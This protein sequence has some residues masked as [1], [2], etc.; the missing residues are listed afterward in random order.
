MTFGERDIARFHQ[1]VE[2]LKECWIWKG[3]KT[4]N[5]YGAFYFQRKIYPAHRFSFIMNNGELEPKK[6][7]LH[8]CDIPLCV[9]PAHL[10]QGTHDENMKDMVRKG[11]SA[12]QFTRKIYE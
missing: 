5:G 6:V 10:V 9:N 8:T 4:G 11:R 1:K 3:A 12:N 7:L 2:K